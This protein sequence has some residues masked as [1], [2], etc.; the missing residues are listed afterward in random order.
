MTAKR[1]SFATQQALSSSEDDCSNDL[2]AECGDCLRKISMAF[3][4]AAFGCLINNN[5]ALTIAVVAS[6]SS[7]SEGLIRLKTH[8]LAST[9]ILNQLLTL[10]K[11]SSA[12]TPTNPHPQ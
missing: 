12:Y 4:C 2:T 5:C 9:S 3:D 7:V 11:V 10:I 6:P 1:K 8:I